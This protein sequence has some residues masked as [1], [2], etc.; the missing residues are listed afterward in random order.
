MRVNNGVEAGEGVRSRPIKRGALYKF[1]IYDF[2][3]PK[4][5]SAPSS[6]TLS[7]YG[8]PGDH[9]ALSKVPNS[10]KVASVEGAVGRNPVSPPSIGNLMPLVAEDILT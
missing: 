9:R 10:G 8:A 3:C 1:A 5:G 6:A 2:P 4:P 7:F